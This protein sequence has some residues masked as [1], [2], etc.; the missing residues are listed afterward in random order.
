MNIIVKKPTK[1]EKSEM[2]TKPVWL[3]LKLDYMGF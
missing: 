2:E 3:E 1:T